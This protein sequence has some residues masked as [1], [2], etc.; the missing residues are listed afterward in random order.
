ME[1]LIRSECAV[2]QRCFAELADLA[3]AIA[4]AAE[5]WIDALRRGRTIF[6]CG[7]GGSAADAQHLA[8]ELVGRY[9]RERRGMPG[10]ALTTD[11]SILSAVAND[12]GYERVFSRQLEAL[13]R[14][15]DVLYAISTS[16]NSRNVLLAM[17]RAKSIGMK[18]IAV[19]GADG[20]RMRSLGDVLLNVPAANANHI[21]E[22]HIAVGHLLCGLAESAFCE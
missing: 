19:T 7:N 22:M 4:S 8:A 9:A 15:G 21:Q 2:L 3:P 1:T 10:I 17:E 13:G 16:G 11:T 20:G 14:P 18:V 5:C 6:F 12:Y